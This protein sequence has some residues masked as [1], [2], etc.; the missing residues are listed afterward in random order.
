[1]ETSV[2]CWVTVQWISLLAPVTSLTKSS[3]DILPSAFLP[4]DTRVPVQTL[5]NR[6]TDKL[7]TTE[8]K[9]QD[10]QQKR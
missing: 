9:P 3:S 1:M 8:V 7:I 2:P 4:P 5:L 10:V 6:N